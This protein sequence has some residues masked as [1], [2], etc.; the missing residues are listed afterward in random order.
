MFSKKKEA[1]GTS[2]FEGGLSM[3]ELRGSDMAESTGD[4]LDEKDVGGDIDYQLGEDDDNASVDQWFPTKKRTLVYVLL[5]M[6]QIFLNFD[7]G[8]ISCALSMLQVRT[9]GIQPGVRLC[10][11]SLC[12]QLLL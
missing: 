2:S 5:C 6:L 10:L 9:Y 7:S 8:A 1:L 12:T 3:N 11:Y 4:L